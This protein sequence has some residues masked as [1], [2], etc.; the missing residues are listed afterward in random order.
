MTPL[1]AELRERLLA[2][3]ARNDALSDP[4]SDEEQ[5]EA[6]ALLAELREIGSLI[7]LLKVPTGTVN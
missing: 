6:A 5:A 3:R 4:D 2:A 1:L 7:E